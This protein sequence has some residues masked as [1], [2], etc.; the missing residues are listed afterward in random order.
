MLQ[1]E[2]DD[3]LTDSFGHALHHTDHSQQKQALELATEH[4][5]ATELS[6]QKEKIAAMRGAFSTFHE[7]F[8]LS[9]TP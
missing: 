1:W 7:K 8:E 6:V 5:S 4:A 9:P 2:H 3:Q